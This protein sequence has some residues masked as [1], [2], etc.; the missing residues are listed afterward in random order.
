MR[1]QSRTTRGCGRRCSHATVSRASPARIALRLA[2]QSTG[3]SRSPHSM[4]MKQAPRDAVTPTIRSGR[5]EPGTRP[6]PSVMRTLGPRPHR[7]RTSRGLPFRSP[8]MAAPDSAASRCPSDSPVLAP[9]RRASCLDNGRAIPVVRC[10]SGQGS[11]KISDSAHT[12]EGAALLPRANSHLRA[13]RAAHSAVARTP[14]ARSRGSVRRSPARRGLETGGDR[15]AV[16]GS[17]SEGASWC[18]PR[19]RDA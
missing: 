10:G 18:R 11:L 1:S 16:R 8:R 5:G 12:T 17:S 7:P 2:N 19:T 13:V 9:L 14:A 6:L 3:A 4:A 15:A